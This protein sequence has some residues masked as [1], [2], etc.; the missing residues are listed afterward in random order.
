MLKRIRADARTALL[1]VVIMT[2]ST[3]DEDVVKSYQLGANSYI[4]KPV[5]FDRFAKAV[6][7]LGL[8]WL[9]LN[10]RPPARS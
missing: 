8:Y 9:V 4:R 6:N 3:E 10:Q 2:S 1:P 7:N 5:E